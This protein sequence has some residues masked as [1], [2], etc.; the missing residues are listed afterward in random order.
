[1]TPKA[2]DHDKVDR[3]ENVWAGDDGGL[4]L[5]GY[6]DW[7]KSYY[8]RAHALNVGPRLHAKFFKTVLGR[9]TTTV[10]FRHRNWVWACPEEGW[11]LYVD[12]RGPAFHVHQGV[13]ANHAW[14]AFGKFRDRVD[15]W[16]DANKSAP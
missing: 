12:R 14:V 16:F 10:L 5:K 9:Q 8:Q 15:A 4:Y 11:I 2:L 1:M 6:W 13:D 7:W 3:P